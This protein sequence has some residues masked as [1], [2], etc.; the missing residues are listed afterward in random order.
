[1]KT[2]A[3]F[4]IYIFQLRHI[5]RGFLPRQNFQ[6]VQISAKYKSEKWR[7]WTSEYTSEVGP[8]AMEEYAS[9]LDRSHP[10]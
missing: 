7:T 2:D 8:D 1:M 9:P 4:G 10:P 6:N 5:Y 3:Y